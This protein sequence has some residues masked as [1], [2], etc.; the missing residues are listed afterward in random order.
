M[1]QEFISAIRSREAAFD[2]ALEEETIRGL[3]DY[4]ETVLDANGLLHLVAPCSPEEFAVRHVLESLTL[5]KFL[6]A[7]ASFADIG[8]GAGLPSIP[9][10]IA[11]S[12][13]RGVLIESKEKK[14]K[15]LSEAV[16]KLGLYK[17]V[18]IFGRQF[19]EVAAPDVDFVTSR[20]LDKFIENVPRLLKWG[21]KRRFLLFGGN[22]MRE[23][24]RNKEIRFEER[25]MPLSDRRFL[26][27][28]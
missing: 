23:A 3:A 26:F 28:F 14:V 24:L 22:S 2:V 4:Y 9:C 13:L 15:F 8:T 11:R 7:G 17:R 12:D 1:R 6:P 27:I 25:L 10:L 16:E 21:G 18:K 5:L 19:S 20:A